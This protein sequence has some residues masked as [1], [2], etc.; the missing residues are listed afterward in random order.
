MEGKEAGRNSENRGGEGKGRR[1]WRGYGIRLEGQWWFWD[2][3]EEVLRDGKG[4]VWGRVRGRGKT[5]VGGRRDEVESVEGKGEEGDRER[6][7]GFLERGKVKRQRQG[8][9]QKSGEMGGGGFNGDLVGGKG[10]GKM[11]ELATEGL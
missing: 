8:V 6:E 9:L 2:E 5:T 7:S 3:E 10:M 11:E 1:I 4:R